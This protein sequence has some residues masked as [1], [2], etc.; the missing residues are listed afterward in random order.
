MS[1][2]ALQPLLLGALA[3]LLGAL[4]LREAVL[5][6]PMTA[7]W[8]RGAVAPLRRAGSEGYLPDEPEM[9]RLGLIG[10]VA[11]AVTVWLAAGLNIAI[12]LG[13]AGPAITTSAVARRRAAYRRAFERGMA[14]VATAVADGLAG[15][16]SPRAALL[17]APEA[18]RGETAAEMRR[19]A[20]ELAHGVSSLEALEGMRRR[21]GSSQ[22][23]AFVAAVGTGVV[24]G[25][26]LA[27]LLRRFAES[28]TDREQTLADARTATAQARFTGLLVVMMPIGALLFAELAMPGFIA[29]ILRSGPAFAALV[30]AG[31]LQVVGY[32]LISRLARIES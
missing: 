16:G 8:V 11:I 24:G 4:A 18:L 13:F 2:T 15:G 6:T 21:L 14:E 31:I 12:V 1:P 26:D 5:A 19:L 10:G 20:C 32:L 25:G 23:D 9:R 30:V 29:G 7:R 22:V 28:S 27:A 3:G 17:S